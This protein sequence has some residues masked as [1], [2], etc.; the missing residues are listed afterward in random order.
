MS[1]G[2]LQ[3]GNGHCG[4]EKRTGLWRLAKWTAFMANLLLILPASLVTC[5]Q[6]AICVYTQPFLLQ[7]DIRAIAD[8]RYVLSELEFE[9]LPAGCGGDDGKPAEILHIRDLR[10]HRI[11]PGRLGEAKEFRPD[12]DK[13][14]PGRRHIPIT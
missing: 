4:S 10:L 6:L 2:R 5:H 1:R 13:E 11:R 8:L 7:D 3:L 12:A 14:L 9:A